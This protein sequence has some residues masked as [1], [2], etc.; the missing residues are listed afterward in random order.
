MLYGRVDLLLGVGLGLLA[1]VGVLAGAR[2]AHAVPGATLRLGCAVA[3]MV[4]GIAIA[5]AVAAG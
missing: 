3:C 2:I 4:A 5:V 1:S